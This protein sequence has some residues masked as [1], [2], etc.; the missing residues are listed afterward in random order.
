MF[1]K[2]I[3][4]DDEELA[5]MRLRKLLATHPEIELVDEAQNGID[6]IEK[7]NKQEPDLIFLDI[8]MPGFNGFEVIK[9][10]KKQPVIIFTTAHDEFAIKAFDEFAIAYLLKP[11]DKEKLTQALKRSKKL[12]QNND[13]TL[14]NQLLE[15]QKKKDFK[16]FISKFGSTI[17]FIPKEQVCFIEAKDKHTFV[18]LKNGKEYLI[19]HSL[20]S[21]ES[22]LDDNFL[23]IHRG[24]FINIF[25]VHEA[26]K[27]GNGKY[28]FT[29]NDVK[30]TQVQSSSS[31]A[32]IIR[33]V[34]NI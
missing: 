6:A 34:L 23:R 18:H 24:Y 2:A 30:Q 5:R 4:V 26:E 28:L 22:L 27:M 13:L 29:L 31:Y 7:I 8:Q 3:V 17:Q 25:F 32:P 1:I 20:N 9:Q 16:Q 12:L 15:F 11:I 19:D 21:L 33:R 14:L 10:L